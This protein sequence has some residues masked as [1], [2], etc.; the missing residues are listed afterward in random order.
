M[1]RIESSGAKYTVA[2]KLPHGLV[3]QVYEEYEDGEAVLGGGVR[4]VKRF[5]PMGETITLN[6]NAM[7][8]GEAPRHRIISGFA[9]TEGVDKDFFD[10]WVEQNKDLPAV[11]N[12]LIYAFEK[13][14]SVEGQA[15][16]D[17]SLRN[18]M[19]PMAIDRDP[20]SPRRIQRG[21]VAA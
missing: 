2:C 7:K 4:V 12:R 5:R 13:L 1:A 14:D 17:A 18:G 9:L 20:R 3:L 16:N 10:R 15:K 11:K 8:F 6:G 19:E 21:Q